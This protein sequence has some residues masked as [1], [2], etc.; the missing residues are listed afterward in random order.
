M[1]GILIMIVNYFHDLAVGTLAAAVF[2]IY[3][4][5]RYLDNHPERDIVISNI[6]R[7]FS[8]LS[9]GALAYIIVGGA[10]R[11]WFFM[12]FE[13]NPAVG[14]GQIAAL[15]FKHIVLVALTVIGLTVQIRYTKKYGRK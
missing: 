6:I 2:V 11:A 1:S 9:Y 5:G 7:R 14:K 4:L 8:L 12:D 3:L 15:V 10:I 13:W